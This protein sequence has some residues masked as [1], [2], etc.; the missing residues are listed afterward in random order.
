MAQWYAQ[1]G[2]QRYGPVSD[3]DI[4]QWY[5]QGRVKPTDYVWSE[6]MANWTQAGSVFGAAAGVGPAGA[7]TP[8]ATPPGYAPSPYPAGGTQYLKPHRGTAVLVLGI[9]SLVV[10]CV[11][12]ILGIIAWTM[13]NTDLR[14]MAAGTMDPS[15]ES[16]TKAGRI[17]G[18]IGT[19]L[20]I[21]GLVIGILWFVFVL[22]FS[23][24]GMRG[25]D[26]P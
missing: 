25:F 4:R 8:A 12:M 15:G 7:A 16:N 13:G 26:G 1:V 5:A 11:G 20:G 3:E 23:H 21:V 2:G 14:E 19:C 6:G 9:L 24:H 10:G 22:S 18:I 17:C